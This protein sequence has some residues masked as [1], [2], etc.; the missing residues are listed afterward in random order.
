[1][2]E[3]QH[4]LQVQGLLFDAE[5]W[6]RNFETSEEAN[7]TLRTRIRALEANE[8]QAQTTT[9]RLERVERRYERER[10]DQDQLRGSMQEIMSK[11][12]KSSWATD[13]VIIRNYSLTALQSPHDA[14]TALLLRLRV[15]AE[16]SDFEVIRTSPLTS[17]PELGQITIACLNQR[18]KAEILSRKSSAREHHNTEIKRLEF[19]DPVDTRQLHKRASDRLIAQVGVASL[20]LRHGILLVQPRA[21]DPYE[22]ITNDQQI[23]EIARRLAL[24]APS[25]AKKK[26]EQRKRMKAQ[27]RQP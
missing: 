25:K 5:H 17:N 3:Q 22:E 24:R 13:K 9:R 7:R 2:F 4:I 14:I 16:P 18:L 23:E 15:P 27:D 19:V 21:N 8:L 26:R 20:S 12:L 11:N 10:T 6:E 1:M